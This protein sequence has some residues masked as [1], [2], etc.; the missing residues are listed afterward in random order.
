MSY[1]VFVN[2]AVVAI[3]KECLKVGF[4][5]A[6]V[7]RA[8]NAVTTHVFNVGES[9]LLDVSIDI[10]E[11]G[12]FATMDTCVYTPRPA[13]ECSIISFIMDKGGGCQF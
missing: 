2:V 13:N 8:W 5:I 7:A 9:E 10:G 12:W 6:G 1:W 3:C 11:G 4:R